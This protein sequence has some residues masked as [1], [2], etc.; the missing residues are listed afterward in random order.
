M[1][2]TLADLEKYGNW[3]AYYSEVDWLNTIEYFCTPRQPNVLITEEAWKIMK[4]TTVTATGNFVAGKSV[5]RAGWTPDFSFAA[6][7]LATVKA[8]TYL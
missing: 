7:D 2:Y 5:V 8:Y 4:V 1:L 3:L 6:T